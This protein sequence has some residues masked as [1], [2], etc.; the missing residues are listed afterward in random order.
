MEV[1]FPR[2]GKVGPTRPAVPVE[3]SLNAPHFH[4][5]CTSVN[6]MRRASRRTRV[7]RW[8]LV[9]DGSDI[10]RI[11]SQSVSI[12]SGTTC[13]L[14][15]LDESQQSRNSSKGAHREIGRER[16]P[17]RSNSPEF[18]LHLFSPAPLS[19]DPSIGIAGEG[20]GGRGIPRQLRS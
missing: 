10:F 8:I 4:V 14:G 5:L 11:E 12:Y 19:I 18:T 16:L 7:R 20:E 2:S 13:Y 9:Y 17:G 3:N 15:A 1:K 6:A